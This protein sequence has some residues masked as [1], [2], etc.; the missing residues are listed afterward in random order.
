MEDDPEV[1]NVSDLVSVL[2]EHKDDVDHG[3]KDLREAADDCPCC[4]LSALVQSGFCKGTGQNDCGYDDGEWY[5]NYVEPL[6]GKDK[7]DFKKELEAFWSEERNMQ[8]QKNLDQGYFEQ[9]HY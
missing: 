8:Q 2:Q 6:I 4:I 1:P 9:S 5:S 3:L 7:F